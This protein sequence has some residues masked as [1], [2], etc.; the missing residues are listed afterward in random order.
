MAACFHR[1][2]MS[3]GKKIKRTQLITRRWLA[4]AGSTPPPEIPE[5]NGWKL[6]DNGYKMLWFQGKATPNLVLVMD[7][8]ED[9][10]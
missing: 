8:A 6:D 10:G 5:N 1:A 4:A 9:E 2:H 3:C 7:I